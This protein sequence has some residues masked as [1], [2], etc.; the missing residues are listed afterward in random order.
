MGYHVTITRSP[1][2]EDDEGRPIKN[3]QTITELEWLESRKK[4]PTL[5]SRDD[6]AQGCIQWIGTESAEWKGQEEYRELKLR[7]RDSQ[8]GLLFWS[9]GEIYSKNPTEP[10]ISKMIEIATLLNAH[11]LGDD[12]EEYL[13][14]GEIRPP[15]YNAQ[16]LGNRPAPQNNHC[17]V[18]D[19][20]RSSTT[21]SAEDMDLF[22]EKLRFF[23]EGDNG[24][25]V[26]DRLDYDPGHSLFELEVSFVP[27]HWSKKNESKS[28]WLVRAEGV[29][30]QRVTR[31]AK[32]QHVGGKVYFGT[33]HPLLK[34]YTEPRAE[35]SINGSGITAEMVDTFSL[36]LIPAMEATIGKWWYPLDA[37][38]SK[39]YRTVLR[40]NQG[41]FAVGPESLLKEFEKVFLQYGLTAELKIM[42]GEDRPSPHALVFGMCF[43]VADNFSAARLF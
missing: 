34:P 42:G 39:D 21:C 29:R 2:R 9:D 27:D 10:V 1:E 12:G 11:V 3:L 16:D 41:M 30:T 7:F 19:A 25:T 13:F 24:E 17:A 5:I 32:E 15:A 36:K 43:I 31:D 37:F 40:R 20:K 6:I 18:S 26:L 28:T 33:D 14:G 4:D 35:L 22:I 38:F 8:E 23:Y